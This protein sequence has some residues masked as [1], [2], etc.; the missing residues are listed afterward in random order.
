MASC[1]RKINRQR[2]MA[3]EKF[4]G[5]KRERKIVRKRERLTETKD[6]ARCNKEKE[7][8]KERNREKDA[9][10]ARKKEGNREGATKGRERRA[11]ERKLA[12]KISDPHTH[13]L[14]EHRAV[15]LH[16]RQV[17]VARDVSILDLHRAVRIPAL[18]PVGGVGSTQGSS[19][20]SNI[21]VVAVKKWVRCGLQR[22][23]EMAG[24][25]WSESERERKKG[26]ER[27]REGERQ[28]VREGEGGGRACV[29]KGLTKRARRRK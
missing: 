2:M 28:R 5:R 9:K 14:G 21:E 23:C 20:L 19:A 4:I 16:R 11:R 24:R 27:G 29:R 1:T 3:K 12:L 10:Y 22:K 6:S 8:Q 7:R 15:Q 25:G 17:E 26:N 13:Y 18:E